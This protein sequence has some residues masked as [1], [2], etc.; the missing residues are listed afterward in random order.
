ML[1][2][3][4]FDKS[5]PIHLN[6]SGGFALSW[7]KTIPVDKLLNFIVM[8]NLPRYSANISRFFFWM[9]YKLISLIK[10]IIF[11]IFLRKLF[12]LLKL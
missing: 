11:L 2:L 5:F 3:A 10:S 8:S 12:F 6:I 4:E 1:A 9:Y 7:L